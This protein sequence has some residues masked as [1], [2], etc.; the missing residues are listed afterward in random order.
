MAD[1]VE[2]LT[3][4]LA[5]L[6]E[7]PVP[8]SLVEIAGALDGQYP[9]GAVARRGTFERDKALLREIGVPI[10][11]EIVTGGPY[12]GQ[13]RYRIDR[14]RYELQDLRL[15]PDELAAL[16]LAVAATRSG[17]R[18][19]RDAL[20]KVGADAGEAASHVV[21]PLPTLPFLPSLREAVA[22]RRV[23]ELDYGGVHRE[24]EPWGLLL[25]D[26]FWYLIGHDRVRGA[27]RTF[28][29]DRI[30]GEPLVRPGAH[31]FER[32][33]GLD[34]RSALAVDPK[35]LGADQQRDAQVLVDAD[36]AAPVVREVGEE[37]VVA[38]RDD[39]AVVLSVA[40]TNV[41]AF[42]S[43]VLGLGEHAEVL[44]PPDVREH[45]VSWLGSVAGAAS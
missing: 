20:W 4:L 14:R 32:P 26:G 43:W 25:R 28:R 18:S 23:V 15:E 39:G 35:A 36:W 34:L 41:D 21:A 44:G 17:A 7:T 42:R 24:V 5:L 33:P 2:R 8:L 22:Q 11:T 1:R 9:D 6:L 37:R 10:E 12:A 13:T 31:A 16:Q 45:L 40:C 30:D 3:N 19:A 38:R 29:V 27:R